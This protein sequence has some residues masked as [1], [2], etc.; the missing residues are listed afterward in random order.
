QLRADGLGSLRLLLP[1]EYTGNYSGLLCLLLHLCSRSH[2]AEPVDHGD[3]AEG[4][5]DEG[6]RQT[7]P[8]VELGK[9][10]RTSP[11]HALGCPE[12]APHPTLDTTREFLCCLGRSCLRDDQ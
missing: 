7:L 11:Q 9:R 1:R 2:A 6:L 5:V 4:K 8:D 12:V 10:L 3:R